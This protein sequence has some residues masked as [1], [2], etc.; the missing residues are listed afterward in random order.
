MIIINRFLHPLLML[1]YNVAAQGIKLK[2]ITKNFQNKKEEYF[3]KWI[4]TT[5]LILLEYILFWFNWVLVFWIWCFNCLKFYRPHSII[6]R[7]NRQWL[8]LHYVVLSRT[9]SGKKIVNW[10]CFIF[11]PVKIKLSITFSHLN[12]SGQLLKAYEF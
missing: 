7:S 10:L 11:L 1:G 12:R 4:L 3:I 8:V 5:R 6:T 9:N 2:I